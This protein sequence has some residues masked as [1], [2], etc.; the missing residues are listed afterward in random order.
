MTIASTVNCFHSF[1]SKQYPSF[2]FMIPSDLYC[3]VTDDHKIYYKNKP[4]G[5]RRYT[6]GRYHSDNGGPRALTR[7]VLRSRS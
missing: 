3:E 4:S 7:Q 5:M 2:I 6:A 1:A